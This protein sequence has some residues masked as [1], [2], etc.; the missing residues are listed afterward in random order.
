MTLQTTEAKGNPYSMKQ[1]EAKNNFNHSVKQSTAQIN[2]Q[3]FMKCLTAQAQ[4]PNDLH[5]RQQNLNRLKE[6]N[7]YKLIDWNYRLIP[8]NRKKAR[9]NKGMRKQSY[10]KHYKFIYRKISI[11]IYINGK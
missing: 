7:I 1:H 2:D 3:N 5:Q 4:K 10:I 8:M 11:V 9:V 6:K